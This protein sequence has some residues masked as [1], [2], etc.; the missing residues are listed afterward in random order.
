MKIAI[1]CA[2]F[3]L[4]AC[5]TPRGHELCQNFCGAGG[6]GYT[7]PHYMG[8]GACLCKNEDGVKIYEMMCKTW[9]P[10]QHP[11]CEQQTKLHLD[12]ISRRNK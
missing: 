1:M 9:N 2:A 5:Q 7:E 4:A 3:L 10:S 11:E 8:A 6:Q 12:E